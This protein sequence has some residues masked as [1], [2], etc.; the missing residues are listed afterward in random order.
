MTRDLLSFLLSSREEEDEEV[1][2]K[3]EEEDYGSYDL[4]TN[5]Q[6]ILERKQTVRAKRL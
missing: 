2:E 3:E 5:T 4:Q 6:L 1:K